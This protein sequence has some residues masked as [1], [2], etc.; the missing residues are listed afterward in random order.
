MHFDLLPM[1]ISRHQ[2]AD[3]GL[4]IA[5]AATGGLSGY[6]LL[7]CGHLDSTSCIVV[8][9][10]DKRRAPHSLVHFLSV[11]RCGHDR[12]DNW[13]FSSEKW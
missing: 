10:I 1:A 6:S 5:G 2:L 7:T 4:G 8:K 12:S 9:A 13:W 3:H 11:G